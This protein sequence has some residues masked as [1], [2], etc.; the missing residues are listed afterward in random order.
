[1]IILSTPALA[2]I[3]DIPCFTSAVFAPVPVEDAC[4]SLGTL[5]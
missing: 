3:G 4:F 1:M 2:K 5:A